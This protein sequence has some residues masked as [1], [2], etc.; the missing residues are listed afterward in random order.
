MATAITGIGSRVDRGYRGGL[1]TMTAD[2]RFLVGPSRV[3]RFWA[4]TGCSGGGFSS[5]QRRPTAGQWIVGGSRRSIATSRR[6]GDSAID[7]AAC[8]VAVSAYELLPP[9]LVGAK[10]TLGS[11]GEPCEIGN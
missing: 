10:H 1:F 9:N 2:G 4:A 6:A 5:S 7:D 3:R 11:E 8:A